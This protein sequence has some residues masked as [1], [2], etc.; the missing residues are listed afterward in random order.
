[1]VFKT[2]ADILLK[3][4]EKH[5][6]LHQRLR[7]ADAIRRW[8][9]AVGPVIAKHAEIA[10]VRKGVLF[11]RVEH[12][13]WRSELHHRKQQILKILNDEEEQ[14]SNQPVIEDLFFI[15]SEAE[16]KRREARAKYLKQLS[17]S[18]SEA[19]PEE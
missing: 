17:E 1:M 16:F 2:L 4:R 5:P 6:V 19:H 9:K 3:L 15:G 12:P 7:E 14:T 13:I 10:F 18:K 11:V 8:E